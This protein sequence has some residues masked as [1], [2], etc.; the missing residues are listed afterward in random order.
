M[1]SP[2]YDLVRIAHRK[3]NANFLAP[4][5]LPFIFDGIRQHL[6]TLEYTFVGL[7]PYIK[8]SSLRG[9]KG[10]LTTLVLLCLL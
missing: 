10:T 4:Y 7:L 2:Y 9:C 1:S 3:L 6:Y 8:G 5:G